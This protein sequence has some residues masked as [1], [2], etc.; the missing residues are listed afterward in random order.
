MSFQFISLRIRYNHC[1]T[2]ITI[3]L[4]GSFSV[5]FRMVR[6]GTYK[7]GRTECNQSPTSY[8]ILSYLLSVFVFMLQTQIHQPKEKLVFTLDVNYLYKIAIA[9]WTLQ[10]QTENQQ[11]VL[12]GEMQSSSLKRKNGNINS[13][14]FILL[15]HFSSRKEKKNRIFDT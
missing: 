14:T 12:F 1:K 7:S 5:S 10:S 11:V 9:N 2:R 6:Y 13:T 8:Y 15:Q 3:M 4:R